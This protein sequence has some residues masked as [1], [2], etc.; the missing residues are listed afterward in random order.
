MLLAG[1]PPWVQCLFPSLGCP[2][3]QAGQLPEAR[4]GPLGSA[5]GP[6]QLPESLALGRVNPSGAQPSLNLPSLSSDWLCTQ[7]LSQGIATSGLFSFSPGRVTPVCSPPPTTLIRA[8]GQGQNMGRLA[9]APWRVAGCF[10]RLGIYRS[11]GFRSWQSGDVMT[12]VTRSSSVNETLS[13]R[14]EPGMAVDTCYLSIW[15][16]R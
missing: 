11:E 4:S 10:G 7:E 14:V 5:P 9:P 2:A 1:Y 16:L 12:V 8:K 13:N 3:L 15:R 6:W